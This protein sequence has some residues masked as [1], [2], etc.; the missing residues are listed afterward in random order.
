MIAE[1]HAC[2]PTM[3]QWEQ[4]RRSSRRQYTAFSYRGRATMRS[5]FIEPR[6]APMDADKNDAGALLSA[7]IRAL[8]SSTFSFANDHPS[9]MNE[10]PLLAARKTS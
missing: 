5:K 2:S 10:R 8:R 9:R 6:I 3:M 1:R 4:Q 7:F